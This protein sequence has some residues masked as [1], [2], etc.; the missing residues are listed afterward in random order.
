M[1]GSVTII[2]PGEECANRTDAAGNERSV[3][4]RF[5]ADGSTVL[6]LALAGTICSQQGS[7]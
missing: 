6:T 1:A 3:D 7:L 5:G 2:S 4:G